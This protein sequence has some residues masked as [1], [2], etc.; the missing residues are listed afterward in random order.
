MAELQV[1]NYNVMKH[2]GTN[3]KVEQ[4]KIQLKVF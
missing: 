3:L 1:R 2:K 4:N